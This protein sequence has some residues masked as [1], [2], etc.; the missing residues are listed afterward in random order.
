VSLFEKIIPYFLPKNQVIKTDLVPMNE[1]DEIVCF[2][3]TAI[4]DTLFNTPVFRSLKQHFPNKKLIV[5]LNPANY[6]LFETNPYIDEIILYDGKTKHFFKALKDLKKIK[7]KLILILHSNDPQA[8]PLAVLSGAKY[9]IKIPNNKNPFNKWHTNLPEKF[10]N[11]KYIIYEKFKFLRYLGIYNENNI[12]MELYIKKEWKKKI[13]QFFIYNNI[14]KTIGFQI[15]TSTISRRWFNERWIELGKKLLEEYP[16]IKII[17]TGAPNEKYLT[18]EVEKGINDKRVI[19]ATGKFNIGE[20]AALIDKLDL[21]ITCD[22]GPLHIAASLNT[23]TI[24]LY[25]A[26]NHIITN[27]G[28]DKEIHRYIQKPQTCNPCISKK[29]KFQECMLQISIEEVFNEIKK[30]YK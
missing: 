5:M 30:V 23:P 12:K 27:P 9:I 29:C 21:L 19:N 1:I 18:A 11:D 7:P 26:M 6:K 25:A 28:F 20:A 10:D 17:L 13:N 2:S 14:S 15:G 8:T 4:G 22:T 24:A 3:N 16:D